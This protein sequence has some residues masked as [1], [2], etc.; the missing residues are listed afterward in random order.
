MRKQ[1]IGYLPDMKNMGMTIA[2]ILTF[3]AEEKTQE[4][5][6]EFFRHNFGYKSENTLRLT[7]NTLVNYGLLEE[8]EDYIFSATEL[9]KCWLEKKS[10]THLVNI[11]NEHVEYISELLLELQKQNLSGEQLT[12]RAKVYYG[13]SLN[14][15]EMSRRCQLLKDAELIKM[16]RRRIYVLTEEGHKFTEAWK[17]GN[18]SDTKSKIAE[19]TI[20]ENTVTENIIEKAE[21]RIE[22]MKLKS[23]DKVQNYA[24]MLRIILRA[25]DEAKKDPVTNGELY[26]RDLYMILKNREE[27]QNDL[28]LDDITAVLDFFVLSID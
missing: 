19:N 21:V 8:N 5:F 18:N 22:P 9:G 14:S 27:I 24:N 11:I 12:E 20:A 17:S 4:E 16:N 7:Q 3:Y 1:G 2:K 15:S 23:D 10:K 28:T 13:L 25:L 26:I 6:E